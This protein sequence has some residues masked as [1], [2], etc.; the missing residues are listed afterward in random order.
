MVMAFHAAPPAGEWL[1]DP[2]GLVATGDGWVLFAQHRADTPGFTASNWA[3]FTSP[4]LLDWRCHGAVIDHN[5]S[6]Q[7]Y[8]GSVVV[9]GGALEAFLTIHDSG[10]EHQQRRRSVDAGLTWSAQLMSMPSSARGPNVRDPFVIGTEGDW[11]MLLACPCPWDGW[12]AAPPSLLRMYR[13]TDKRAW[14]EVGS[15]GPWHP[16][17]VI[18]EVPALIRQAGGDVLLISCV[19]RRNSG[20]DCSVTA[21]AGT[22]ADTDFAVAVGWPTAGQ[23]VDL[24]PDFYAAIPATGSAQDAPVVGWL[25]SWRTARTMAW[26]GFAGGPIGLPRQ[27]VLA[28]G[29]LAHR[30]FPTLSKAFVE[31]CE[32]VPVAGLGTAMFDG[33]RNFCI[34]IHGGKSEAI[35]AGNVSDSSLTVSRTGTGIVWH[36]FHP[37]SLGTALHRRIEIFVDGPALEIFL[38]PDGAAI[39]M[40]LPAAGPFAITLHVGDDPVPLAWKRLPTIES[41]GGAK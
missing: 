28:A 31:K 16:P 3:R 15:I 12:E 5:G 29:R 26:P 18:W 20:A 10:D 13:S 38:G 33:D 34:D 7:A 19:D 4:N 39:S 6:A 2:N 23:R 40:A 8:S 24:G 9:D 41:V 27:L 32:G 25:G 14:R 37:Q 22:V 21:W 30:P 35:I 11:L 17:G 1:N 36:R